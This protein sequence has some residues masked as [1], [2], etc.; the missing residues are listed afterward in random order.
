MAEI[1]NSF[2][3]E[4][5]CRDVAEQLSVSFN[6]VRAAVELLDDGNTL[7]FIARYRKEATKGLDEIAL[8]TMRA[9]NLRRAKRRF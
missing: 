3:I 5:F 1:S 2:P 9:V 4:Q 7:P 8:R 6:Q